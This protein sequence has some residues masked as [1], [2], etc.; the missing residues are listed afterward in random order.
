MRR[1]NVATQQ[2]GAVAETQPDREGADAAT[3]ALL[4]PGFSTEAPTESLAVSGN[5]ANIDRG[6]MGERLDAIMRGEFN[7][8]TGE[9]AQGF[10]PGRGGPGGQVVR[11]VRAADAAKAR[12]DAGDPAADVADPATS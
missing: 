1:L 2:A 10:G 11:V 8:E 12:A 9:F 5:M 7:P 4:P 6:M 3:R